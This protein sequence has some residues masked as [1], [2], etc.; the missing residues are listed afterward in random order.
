MVCAELTPLKEDHCWLTAPKVLQ[1]TSRSSGA[2]GI[3]F[4]PWSSSSLSWLDTQDPLVMEQSDTEVRSAVTSSGSNLTGQDG[5][6]FGMLSADVTLCSTLLLFSCEEVEDI[7]EV[8][9]V[10]SI[11]GSVGLPEP[12]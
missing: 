8:A 12:C 11:G 10:I 3:C 7:A 6:R 2:A 1:D 9:L 5:I 4:E